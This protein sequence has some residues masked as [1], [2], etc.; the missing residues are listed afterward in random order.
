[1]SIDEESSSSNSSSPTLPPY[2]Y[3]VEKNSANSRQI[4]EIKIY[5]CHML[6]LE[7]FLTDHSYVGGYSPNSD[8]NKVWGIL[9]K[10]YPQ[11]CPSPEEQYASIISALNLLPTE[12]VGP[13]HSTFPCIR[14]WS[15]HIASFSKE[16]RI[17]FPFSDRKL[18]DILHDFEEM[19]YIGVKMHGFTLSLWYLYFVYLL[20]SP[21]FKTLLELLR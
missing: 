20:Q 5:W 7:Y 13:L 21:H 9:V 14:R 11:F 18:D 4:P 19:A 15:Y 10:E 8:D 16:N 2:R 3:C 1:M 12:T 6:G 17:N